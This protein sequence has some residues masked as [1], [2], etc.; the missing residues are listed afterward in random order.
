MYFMAGVPPGKLGLMATGI[1]NTVISLKLL[2]K[3]NLE[4]TLAKRDITNHTAQ[5]GVEADSSFSHAFIILVEKY[6]PSALQLNAGVR[7]TGY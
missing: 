7:P 4:H 3:A 6:V 1:L 5:Q 2:S